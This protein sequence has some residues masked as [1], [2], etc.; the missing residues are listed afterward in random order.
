M[1]YFAGNYDE[2]INDTP[3]LFIYESHRIL[4]AKKADKIYA[5]SD[6]CPHLGTSL[7]K[8]AIHDGVVTCKSH[9]TKINIENGQVLENAHIGFLKFP[10]KDAKT[11]PILIENNQVF[12]MID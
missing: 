2:F 1:K 12:V 5:I 9:G 10:T 8:G 6:K 4:I 3:H 11:Y 7:C